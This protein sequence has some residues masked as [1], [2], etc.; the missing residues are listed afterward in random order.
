MGS[1]LWISSDGTVAAYV[2][3]NKDTFIRPDRI[4]H[5]PIKT[6]PDGRKYVT[7]RFKIDF[8]VSK[9]VADCWCPKCPN[10]GKRYMLSHK[11][12][13]LGNNNCTNLEWLPYKY[14]HTTDK[15]TVVVCYGVGLTVYKDGR[16]MEGRKPISITDSVGDSDLD[17]IRA[18][19]PQ[20][21]I[22]NKHVSPDEIMKIAGY[23]QG[24]D[25]DLIN[26]VILH[27][28]EDCT[29]FAS[30]N[31]EFCEN[32]DPR[33]ISYQQKRNEYLNKRDEELNPN[34]KIPECLKHK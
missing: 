27:I 17:L 5:P 34:T 12:G 30:S 18:I 31:L 11:D 25:A 29:N 23:I 26:P 33:Y 14:K 20:A 16:I 4:N 32:T 8:S 7:N 28:D 24:D 2:V 21:I 1:S 10:D 6:W 9:L 15:K 3:K 13:N 22:S 19:V